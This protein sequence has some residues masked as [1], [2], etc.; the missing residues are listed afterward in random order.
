MKLINFFRLLG[1]SKPAAYNS[2][3]ES[4]IDFHHHDSTDGSELLDET[5]HMHEQ[6]FDDNESEDY[7]SIF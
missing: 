2:E 4:E 7:Y 3:S 5:V 6:P 1:I